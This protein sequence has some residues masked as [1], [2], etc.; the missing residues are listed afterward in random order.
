[1]VWSTEDYV[2]LEGKIPRTPISQEE[3][4]LQAIIS[5]IQS[6]LA[7]HEHYENHVF[8]RKTILFVDS[9]NA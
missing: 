9:N 5:S 3:K 4:D 1:M 2:F 8:C 6:T 7:N